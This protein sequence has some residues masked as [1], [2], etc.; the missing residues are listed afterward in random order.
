VKFK[1]F[2][3]FIL[4]YS[5]VAQAG[6]IKIGVRA[7]NGVSQGLQ[8]WQKTADYLTK[9]IPEHEFIIV[10]VVGI[11]DMLTAV[12]RNE[13]DFVLSNPSM[14]VEL[15]M[16]SGVTQLVTLIN[17]RQNKPYTKF[18]SVIFTRSDRDDINDLGDL[19][20]KSFVAVS[21][22]GFGGWLVAL[23]ELRHL[24][25]MPEKDFSKLSF[26][27]SLQQDV[28]YSVLNKEND[29]GVVRTDMLERMAADGLINFN[30]F[31]VLNEKVTA[32]FPFVHSTELYPEWPLS[33]SKNTS[34]NLAQKVS[35]A[36]LT[37]PENH[38]AAK[39]GKYIGWTVVEDYQPVRELL[40][41]LKI[42]PFEDYG[43]IEI[44]TLLINYLYWIVLVI[45]LMLFFLGVGI[46]VIGLNRSLEKE[47]LKQESYNQQLEEKMIELNC[48]Y[49][50][51][52]ILE[53][54][55]SPDECFDQV[56]TVLKDVLHKRADVA[57]RLAY[58]H[59][60]FL[61]ESFKYS[62]YKLSSEIRENKFLVGVVE[63]YYNGID[64]DVDA[65]FVKEISVLIKEVSIRLS[66]Y[67]DNRHAENE[68]HN[69]NIELEKRVAE[70]TKELIKA[71]E[72]AEL[73][74]KAKSQFMS[75][76][77]HELRTPLNAITGFSQ[78]LM[79]NKNCRADEK[80]TDQVNEIKKAGDYLLF[81]VSDL[82]DLSKVES[83]KYYLSY[84]N[85]EISELLEDTMFQLQPLADEYNITL[86]I[87]V[88]NNV[89]SLKTDKM[90]LKQIL[91]NLGVNAIK[92]NREN[93]Q[94]DVDVT[95]GDNNVTTF[96]V[97][98]TGFGFTDEQKSL[99]FNEFERLGRDTSEA[100]TGIGLTLVKNLVKSLG[101]E[102]QA[103]SIMGR[104]ARFWFDIPNRPPCNKSTNET[105]NTGR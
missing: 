96:S 90:V 7:H 74:S 75:K 22:K 70:R 24:G 65:D 101:G 61:S 32:N 46:Y 23:R 38:P 91:S 40:K 56:I 55:E 45:G 37:M 41:E 31:K 100:G 33:K 63:L 35:L 78:L 15:E 57:L 102:I 84:S 71:K 105:E 64:G 30:D 51:S 36:L 29:A 49:R 68:L 80:T 66:H 92:Y 60:E 2:L 21:P 25:I 5:G 14:A 39:A 9:A 42:G 27:N 6:L 83:G 77:S 86:K 12:S 82:L 47:K 1:F 43:K 34:S 59:Q 87:S 13:F 11:E 3:L 98:D 104:G 62:D 81:L 79:Q 26:S 44:G 52:S 99:M 54:E 88:A 10:P 8:Q 58:K 72:S 89:R 28:V 95:S 20:G 85:V 103:E 50:V 18:G 93:G 19:K 69:I 16:R 53:K 76:M 97:T 94:V 67:L 73:A 17:N 4:L 48:L